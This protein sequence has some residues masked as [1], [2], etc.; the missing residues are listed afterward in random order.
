MGRVVLRKTRVL[1][2]LRSLEPWLLEKDGWS[3]RRLAAREG[4]R[5]PQHSQGRTRA[6]PPKDDR[7]LCSDYTAIKGHFVPFS[8]RQDCH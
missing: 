8:K 2:L 6:Q 5:G 7:E 4:G 3:E 1:G